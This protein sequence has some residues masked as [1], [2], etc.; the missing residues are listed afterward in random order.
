M[1]TT[2]FVISPQAKKP[3]QCLFAALFSKRCTKRYT[4]HKSWDK[5]WH[6]ICS[7]GCDP[8]DTTHSGSKQFFSFD[9]TKVQK[10]IALSSSNLHAGRF[11]I[12]LTQV[13]FCDKPPS[14]DKI[15]WR[16]TDAVCSKTLSDLNLSLT[17]YRFAVSKLFRQ[18]N[19]KQKSRA[20]S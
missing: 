11:Y 18:L 12:G 3:T 13:S 4:F 1:L 14:C 17:Y 10:F 16:I 15:F 2:V 20:N 6:L 19:S 5:N 8:L 9:S 7:C